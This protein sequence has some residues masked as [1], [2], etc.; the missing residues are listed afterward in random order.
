MS[1]T[2][3]DIIGEVG[4]IK[5]RCQMLLEHLSWVERLVNGS[6][7]PLPDQEAALT[8]ANW[9]WPA[10]AKDYID[11]ASDAVNEWRRT[12]ESTL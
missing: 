8:D 10:S 12:I 9:R 3:Q 5:S 4:D 11:R 2:T 6:E 1:R 7:D